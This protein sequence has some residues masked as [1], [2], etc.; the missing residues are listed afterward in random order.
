LKKDQIFQKTFSG[1]LFLK[2]SARLEM[3]EKRPNFPKKLL[4]EIFSYYFIIED[5][6]SN[7]FDLS[8]PSVDYFSP[9]VENSP[10]LVTLIVPE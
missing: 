8:A 2:C 1:N 7:V 4:Q 10:N 3:F 6:S 5:L 9:N